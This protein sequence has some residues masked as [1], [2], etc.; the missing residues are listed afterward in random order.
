MDKDPRPPAAR[1]L[2]RPSSCN[3]QSNH[4]GRHNANLDQRSGSRRLQ[5]QLRHYSRDFQRPDHAS[6][7]GTEAEGSF[8]GGVRRPQ[9]AGE[10]SPGWEGS[11]SEGRASGEE[12]QRL[13]WLGDEARGKCD[14]EGENGEARG[15]R[16]CSTDSYG[17]SVREHE[18]PRRTT[19]SQRTKGPAAM[20]STIQRIE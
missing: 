19:K 13:V 18:L 3:R 4:C 10:L 9:H 8:A 2:G 7:A 20:V 11:A 12:L 16:L 15:W 14:F 17:G 6:L 1:H 5:H